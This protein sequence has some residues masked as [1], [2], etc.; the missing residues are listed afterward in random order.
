M[1]VGEAVAT[2]QKFTLNKRCVRHSAFISE[3]L[4][5]TPSVLVCDW[6][7]ESV[8]LRN[9]QTGVSEAWNNFSSLLVAPDQ[10]CRKRFSGITFIYKNNDADEV[11]TFNILFS[12]IIFCFV[13]Y[14]A[15]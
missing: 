6:A 5:L 7:S 11:I 10:T 8:E 2:L 4:N 15:S 14:E 9:G 1:S 12:T 3:V 13:V